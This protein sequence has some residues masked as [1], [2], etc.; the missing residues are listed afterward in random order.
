M[1]EWLIG[2]ALFLLLLAALGA[3]ADRMDEDRNDAR[4]RNR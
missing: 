4:R 3:V 1:T 2:C